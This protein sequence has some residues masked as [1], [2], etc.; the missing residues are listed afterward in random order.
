MARPKRSMD[1]LASVLGGGL[2]CRDLVLIEQTVDGSPLTVGSAGL[3]RRLRLVHGIGPSLEGF[4]HGSGYDTL[5]QLQTHPVFGADAASCL[6]ALQERDWL[7]LKRRGASA[8]ALARLFTASELVFLDVETM[9]LGFSQE[10]FLVGCIR[11]RGSE[12]LLQQLVLLSLDSQADLLRHATALL[13]DAAV[14][15]TYNGASFD[16]P[17]LRAAM[18]FHDL[19]ASVFDRLLHIDLLYPSRRRYGANLPDCRLQTIEERIL[20]H[21]R[22]G[23]L[24]GFE[25]PGEYARFAK[26]GEV[27]IIQRILDHNRQ[28]LMTLRD[29]MANEVRDAL[30]PIAADGTDFKS[31]SR[32]RA[33]TST[34]RATAGR[35]RPSSPALPKAEWAC[36]RCG[37][38]TRNRGRIYCSMACERAARKELTSIRKK[39]AGG[40]QA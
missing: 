15:A 24:P 6:E 22:V 2:V 16:V 17:F 9:G 36:M 32:V 37:Q 35:I 7:E 21:S 39:P 20:G 18:E 3:E 26:S 13:E 5:H 40:G 34:L 27:G 10:I 29:L 31:R 1:E 19:D 8:D 11:W 33:A 38:P 30:G 25:I 28:D 23:D 4:F 12:W 14:C